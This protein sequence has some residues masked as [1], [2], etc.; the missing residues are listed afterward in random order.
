[1]TQIMALTGKIHERRLPTPDFTCAN[2]EVTFK[3]HSVDN[4]RPQDLE[5]V[6]IA[7]DAE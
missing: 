5:A 6:R 2:W 7:C 1:M 3:E 4:R